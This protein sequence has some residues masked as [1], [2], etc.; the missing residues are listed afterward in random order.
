MYGFF[1]VFSHL[2]LMQ[3]NRMKETFRT[4]TVAVLL[5]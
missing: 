5:L 4:E 2:K 1:Y 3:L